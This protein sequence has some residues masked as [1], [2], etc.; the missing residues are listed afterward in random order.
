MSHSLAQHLAC[1][2]SSAH[3][4]WMNKWMLKQMNE[5]MHLNSVSED[6]LALDHKVG[7]W[8]TPWKTKIEFAF[9][10]AIPSRS[11]TQNWK[12][13]RCQSRTRCTYRSITME[14]IKEQCLSEK[15]S[16]L[17]GILIDF[18]SDTIHPCWHVLWRWRWC[19]HRGDMCEADQ[20]WRYREGRVPVRGTVIAQWRDRKCWQVVSAG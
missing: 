7:K 2:R 11:D 4:C 8:G 3:V 9:K 14:C 1:S 18:I 5:G 19:Q 10:M 6:L 13:S 20:R 15:G 16:R 12:W 17:F